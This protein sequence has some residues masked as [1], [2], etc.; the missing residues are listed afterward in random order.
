MPQIINHT[1]LSDDQIIPGIVRELAKWSEGMGAGSGSIGFKRPSMFNRQ[2]YV[3]PDSPY[4]QFIVAREAVRNDNIVSG[5]CEVTSALTFQGMKWE[6]TDP[7]ET[8]VFNQISRDLDLDNFSRLWFKEDY[9]Y[10]QA[11]IGMWWGSKTYKVRGNNVTP[12]KPVKIP[13]LEMPLAPIF[14]PAIDEN[15]GKP[16]KPKKIK[17]K[18]SYNVNVPVGLTF[19]DPMKVIPVSPTVFGR[20]RLIWQSSALEMEDIKAVKNGQ[21]YDPI[22]EKFFLDAY[23][24]D[25]Y[26]TIELSR[27]GCDPNYLIELNP[28]YV[29][30]IA[31]TRAPYERF[32]D[33]RL[34][35]VFPL[36]D[37]KQQ[38]IE[39]DRV[40]LVG[41]ANY[42]LLVKL[43]TDNAPAHQ[44][45]LDALQ[46][47]MHRLA[48]VP[49]LV[50]DHRL[51]IEIIVPDQQYSLDGARYDVLDDRILHRCLGAH[52]LASNRDISIISRTIA[53]VMEA[54]R[55]S[56]RRAMEKHFAEAI[57]EANPQLVGDAP[58]LSFTPRNVQLDSDAQITQAV[59]A[60]R[61]Q[62]ELSRETTLDYFGF[63]VEVEALRRELEDESGQDDIFGTIVPFSS[64]G[65][66]PQ[67]AGGA[68]GRPMGGGQSPANATKA[69][70]KTSSGAPSTKK[71]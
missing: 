34:K 12:A 6:G 17:K 7:D 23:V 22:L 66:S 63:D 58:N 51:N 59:L 43:G 10:S 16:V 20:D 71:S 32:P 27:W 70:P 54:K 52:N 47:G 14:N 1:G 30:R 28:D 44:K 2:Q 21:M 19:L 55:L 60:L 37:L 42:I 61:T 13:N 68:G 35:S 26:E 36:L 5:V 31:P 64:P 56:F 3:A 18:K 11:V 29:F 40:A 9:T 41:Q 49:V 53:R 46:E 48:K 62:K 38:L 8:D 4:S 24:P 50:G 15:T 57:M 69:T 67:V 65:L 33:H 25:R 45:E 39:A